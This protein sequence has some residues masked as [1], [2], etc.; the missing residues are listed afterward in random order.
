MPHL[1]H[2]DTGPCQILEWGIRHFV[3]N[4]TDAALSSC[5]SRFSGESQ[6][7]GQVFYLSR[8][9]IFYLL[10]L[11]I[12]NEEKTNGV[13]GNEVQSTWNCCWKMMYY[14]IQLVFLALLSSV[15]TELGPGWIRLTMLPF[16]RWT[17]GQR[18]LASLP[19]LKRLL[20]S[21]GT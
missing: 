19:G 21:G 1:R 20:S 6:N 12:L 14:T 2:R 16:S 9:N 18:A 3:E 8:L 11:N 17:E 13:M 5:S 4:K 15:Y 10:Y 7:W